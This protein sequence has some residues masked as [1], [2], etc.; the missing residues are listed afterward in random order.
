[1][2]DVCGRREMNTKSWWG[3]MKETGHLDHVDVDWKI[4]L[5]WILRNFPGR[6]WTAFICVTTGTIVGLLWTR[7][8]TAGF[9][10]MWGNTLTGWGRK[11]LL[12][13]NNSDGGGFRLV[14]VCWDRR[15]NGWCRWPC[16]L[17]RR[18]EAVRLLGLWVRILL[19]VWMPVAC[20]CFM[21]CR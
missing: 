12:I 21:L 15:K 2:W 5:K 13:K 17:K 11:C 9:H 8:W 4:I 20:V 19:R 16:S 18:S 10:K 3:N 14:I 7:Q 1:M 6:A